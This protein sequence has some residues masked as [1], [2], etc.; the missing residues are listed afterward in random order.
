MMDIGHENINEDDFDEKFLKEFD[1]TQE[2]VILGNMLRYNHPPI[3]PTD[4]FVH[5]ILS[6][7]GRMIS[8]LQTPLYKSEERTTIQF[9]IMEKFFLNPLELY[10]E[11]KIKNPHRYPLAVDDS[12]H[13]VIQSVIV[14]DN[15]GQVIE[16]IEDY[17]LIT[18]LY[19]EEYLSK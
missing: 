7:G 16:K 17:P 1:V 13:S 10:I 8:T 11:G 5:S 3:N 2:G 18:S 9:K 19:F 15:T 14:Y 4:G 6:N 12:F